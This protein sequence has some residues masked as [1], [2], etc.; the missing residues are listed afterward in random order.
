[1]FYTKEQLRNI[2]PGKRYDEIEGLNFEWIGQ[3]YGYKNYQAYIKGLKYVCY[4]PENCYTFN[5]NGIP[6]LEYES[7]YTGFDFLKLAK[8]NSEKALELFLAVDWQ[9]PECLVDEGF[10]DEDDQGDDYE[11]N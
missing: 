4:I 11:N 2:I 3:G 6:E 1:M 7:C 8:G 9:H 5:E 10:F